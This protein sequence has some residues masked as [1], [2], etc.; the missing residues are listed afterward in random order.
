[1]RI[2]IEGS[3]LPGRSIAPGPGFPG[4]EDIQVAVQPKARGGKLLA[5][6]PGDADSVAWTLDCTARPGATGTELT[7]PWIQGRP[8]QRFVYLWWDGV[9]DTGARVMFRRAKLMLDAVDPAVL[10]AALAGGT[11]TARLTLTDLRG[12]PLCAAVRPPSVTWSAG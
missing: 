4:Y 8:G 3:G 6:Q 10:E 9:D 11:L 1:M 5:P 7:G 2:R 12:H